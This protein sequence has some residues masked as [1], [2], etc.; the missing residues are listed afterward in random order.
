MASSKAGAGRAVQKS[1]TQYSLVLEALETTIFDARER[2]S[3][4][5]KAMELLK[6]RLPDSQQFLESLDNE[7]SPLYAD[8]RFTLEEAV[9]MTEE[10]AEEIGKGMFPE[11]SEREPPTR[12]P[13]APPP[14]RERRA[15]QRP[16]PEDEESGPPRKPGASATPSSQ[17]PSPEDGPPRKSNRQ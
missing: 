9:A 17:A 4:F 5:P 7:S 2:R 6:T 8:Y 14:E 13:S 1:L 15:A 10:L 11:V 12:M 3:P 16:T